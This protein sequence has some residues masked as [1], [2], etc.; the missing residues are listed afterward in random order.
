MDA[1]RYRGVRGA[2][3]AGGAGVT[4]RGMLGRGTLGG[5]GMLG[6]GTVG[7]GGIRGGGTEGGCIVVGT[8]LPAGTWISYGTGQIRIAGGWGEATLCGSSDCACACASGG[9]S[10]TGGGASSAS[11]GGV[12]AASAGAWGAS[13]MDGAGSYLRFLRRLA[14]V[15]RRWLHRLGR[16][17]SFGLDRVFGVVVGVR[18]NVRRQRVAVAIDGRVARGAGRDIRDEEA[19]ARRPEQTANDPRQVGRRGLSLD[20]HAYRRRKRSASATGLPARSS[21]ARA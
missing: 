12:S 15:G 13:S 6:R 5:G 3:T 8:T 11:A 4:G 18:A 16:L 19:E 2:G 7:G 14:V 9:A 17:R 1:E 21:F 10:L 20:V